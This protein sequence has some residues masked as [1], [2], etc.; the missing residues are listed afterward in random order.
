MTA[1]PAPLPPSPFEEMTPAPALKDAGRPYEPL[2]AEELEAV[3]SLGPVLRPYDPW[4]CMY[5]RMARS[6]VSRRHDGGLASTG[7]DPGHQCRTKLADPTRSRYCREHA[8]Q[9]G[10][11]YYDPQTETE[12]NVLEGHNMLYDSVGASIATML[13]VMKDPDTP[14][15][16][17]AKTAEA[18]LDRTGFVRGFKLEASVKVDDSAIAEEIRERLDRLAS[19][20]DIS[21]RRH[22]TVDGDVVAQ[23]T[24]S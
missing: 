23:D 16:V 14:A 13:E 24:P 6:P 3:A 18:I 15:G 1:V 12:L 4:R 11:D 7:I 21:T 20:T 17:R 19:V 22:P 9:M 8:R 10:V 5:D 2:T